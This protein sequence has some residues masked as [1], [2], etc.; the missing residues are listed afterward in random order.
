MHIQTFSNM[1]GII[2]GKDPKRIDCDRDGV[3]RIGDTEIKVLHD[4]S[5]ILPML[6]HG[7]TGD[8]AATFTDVGGN[9]YVLDKV[10]VRNGRIAPP[11]PTTVELMELRCRTDKAEAECRELR[12]SI[13]LLS[14]I[15]D[16]NSLNFLIG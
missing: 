2:H 14:G 7:A 3:L 4:G 8:Y 6:F 12:K 15:F 9:T 16:T 5:S 1:K 13:D 11:L 10:K